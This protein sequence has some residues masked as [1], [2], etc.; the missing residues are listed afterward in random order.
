MLS[1]NR[2]T[3]YALVA[4]AE[5]A[6]RQGSDDPTASARW[7]ADRYHLPL[8]LLMNVLK[9][10]AAAGLVNSTRGAQGGY[11][12]ARQPRQIHLSQIIEAM[13]G[14][15]RLTPCAGH[16]PATT[17]AAGIGVGSAARESDTPCDCLL[18]GDCPV[19][20]AIL[21]LHNRIDGFLRTVTLADLL[22][23]KVDVPVG[24]VAVGA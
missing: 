20:H 17:A 18:R 4:L 7:I 3:D 19:H 10:L 11:C 24:Q 14:P 22:E 13:E 8:A 5:L 23:S 15:V 1:L 16:P 6:Q 2:K 12:L 9:E 21:R